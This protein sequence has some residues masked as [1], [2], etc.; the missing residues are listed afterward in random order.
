M[1]FKTTSYKNEVFHNIT[2]GYMFNIL[3]LVRQTVSEAYSKVVAS[4]ISPPVFID[5]RKVVK[6]GLSNSLMD[7]EAFTLPSHLF[8]PEAFNK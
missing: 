3:V 5:S 2:Q 8:S 7:V 6:N 4:R 1:K